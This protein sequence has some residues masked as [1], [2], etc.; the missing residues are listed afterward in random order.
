MVLSLRHMGDAVILSG[1]VN[2]LQSQYP[3]MAVDILGRSGL[4][5]VSRAFSCFR[6]Y[7]DIDLPFYGHHRRDAAALKNALRT[8]SL[9]RHRNYDYCINTIGDVRENLIARLVSARTCIAPVWEPGNLF[10]RKMTDKWASLFPHFG[11]RIPPTYTSYYDSL[12]YFARRLG[13]PGLKWTKR[14]PVK[15]LTGGPFKVALH[16][17]ASHPSRHWPAEKWR[18]V[19]REL[20]SQGFRLTLL[21]SPAEREAL[22]NEFAEEIMSLQLT[23]VADPIHRFMEALS[24]AD[25]LIGMDSFSVHAA[26]ALGVPAVVLN[27]SADARILTPPGNVAVGAGH[28]C[29]K[30]PC[31]YTFPCRKSDSEYIC[32]RGIEIKTVLRALEE[33]TPH[34]MHSPGREGGAN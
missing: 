34:R 27:G 17:G 19:I 30:Y 13:V 7:I 23:L 16:P 11:V 6:E 31:Y 26:Y 8:I 4:Q 24:D 20:R 33:L 28:L 10:K 5:E 32:V 14:N 1:L 12:E 21:G 25:L 15:D 3:D 9:L 22:Q 2:A 29:P 18:A